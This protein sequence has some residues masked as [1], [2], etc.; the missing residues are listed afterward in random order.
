MVKFAS[1]IVAGVG[2]GALFAAPAGSSSPPELCDYS[3]NTI[4]WTQWKRVDGKAFPGWSQ[5]DAYVRAG[6]TLTKFANS[7]SSH[8]TTA[9]IDRP[10]IQNYATRVMGLAL[11][12]TVYD[13]TFLLP[14]NAQEVVSAFS[15]ASNAVAQRQ[16]EWASQTSCIPTSIGTPTLVSSDDDVIDQV[17]STAI[18]HTASTV[19]R[20]IDFKPS[21]TAVITANTHT[22]TFVDETHQRTI[23]TSTVYAVTGTCIPH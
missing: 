23:T 9:R 1:L 5:C 21:G 16:A 11:G 10:V 2:L 22:E 3:W 20:T 4:G 7:T 12:A 6:G 18:N 8:T 19:A 15:D 13:H 14:V 17:V